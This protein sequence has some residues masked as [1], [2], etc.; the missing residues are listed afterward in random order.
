MTYTTKSSVYVLY[1][2]CKRERELKRVCGW[3][4]ILCVNELGELE[5]LLALNGSQ[6]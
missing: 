4:V 3:E 6:V 5:L 2:Y 1:L